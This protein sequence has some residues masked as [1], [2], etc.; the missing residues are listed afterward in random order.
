MRGCVRLALLVAIAA[1]GACGPSEMATPRDTGWIADELRAAYG[2]LPG[3]I[4]YFDGSADLNGDGDPEVIVHVVGPML[5][6]TGGCNTLVFT[7]ADSGYRLVADISVTRP[8]VRVS[9]QT[10]YGWRNLLVQV[11]GGGISPG[12]EAE[13]RFDGETYP[14]NPTVPPAEP[15]SDTVG[16]ESLIPEFEDF[17]EGTLVSQ[18]GADTGGRGETDEVTQAPSPESDEAGL[19]SSGPLGPW[20]WVSFQGMDDSTLE[21]DDPARYTLEI[22]ADGV[23]VL[24]DC[25]RGRGAVKLDGSMIEFS[26]IATTRMACPPASLADRYLGYLEYVRSWVLADGDLYLSLMADG[27]ILRFRPGGEHSPGP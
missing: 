7:P 15:A 21:V 24:A 11:S 2:D 16:A 9:P 25:N 26:D 8:P 3:E 14:A 1:G 27:G 10:S 5:C 4:R 17:R 18:G 12:Y 23:S 20:E 6:G 22:R 19:A 13:L